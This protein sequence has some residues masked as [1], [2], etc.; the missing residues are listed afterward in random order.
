[1]NS[2]LRGD[3]VVAKE[4]FEQVSQ[5]YEALYGPYHPSTANSMI[6]LATVL[7]DLQEYAQSIP[8]YEKAIEARKQIEGENS[9]NYAMAKAMA[10]GSYR[11]LGQFDIAEQYLK[12]AYLKVAV[13]FGEENASAAVILNSMGMLY[14]KQGKYERSL[15]AY[16]RAL[17][18]REAELGEDHPDCMATRH[19]IAELYITWVN[20]VKASEYL[21]KNIELMEQR[22]EKDKKMAEMKELD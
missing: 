8:I 4:L 14:E 17:N 2:Q 12:D 11:E 19:N 21:Q 7:K 15:D 6:N 16:K 22:A 13:E 10:A 5:E 18:V 1:M 9:M 3:Y 20:P